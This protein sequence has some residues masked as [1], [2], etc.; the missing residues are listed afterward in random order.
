MLLRLVTPLFQLFGLLPELVLLLVVALN[1]IL[2]R[3]DLAF[4]A[5]SGRTRACRP[6]RLQ[7]Q[8]LPLQVVD[9]TPLCFLP[10]NKT[11]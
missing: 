11:H 4:I 3:S 1:F 9:I 6:K 2:I 8:F 10:D 5:S 7:F